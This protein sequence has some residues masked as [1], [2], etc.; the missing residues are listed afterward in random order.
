MARKV[1][2]TV[3]AE[4]VDVV[5]LRDVFGEHATGRHV[6]FL[7]VDAEGFDLEVLRSNDWNQHRPT[8]VFVE[9]NSQFAPITQW[10]SEQNY[11]L[12]FNNEDNGLYV[13]K[14]TTDPHVRAA[15]SHA[16]LI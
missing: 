16:A 10:L 15:L 7:S 6:D 4:E 1:G 3:K 8:L 9:I 13:D 2:S 12:I 11:L 14:H 5:P